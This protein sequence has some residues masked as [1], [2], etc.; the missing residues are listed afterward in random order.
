[1][2]EN[3][4]CD[5]VLFDYNLMSEARFCCTGVSPCSPWENEECCWKC[6]ASDVPEVS[7]VQRTVRGEFGEYT[8]T[9]Q[10]W[11]SFLAIWS[12]CSWNLDFISTRVLEYQR[13]ES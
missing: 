12:I 6:S 2:L 7:A 8:I 13:I 5:K 1:M 11:H 4:A 3:S 10:T 9:H